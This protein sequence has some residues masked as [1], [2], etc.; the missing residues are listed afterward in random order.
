MKVVQERLRFG[1]PRARRCLKMGRFRSRAKKSCPRE[2]EDKDG[3]PPQVQPG[4]VISRRT[5]RWAPES[6][7]LQQGGGRKVWGQVGN[8]TQG[9]TDK[10]PKP[11]MWLLGKVT[12]GLLG[13]GLLNVEEEQVVASWPP[14]FSK[15]VHLLPDP[16]PDITHHL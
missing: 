5:V 12:N 7:F 13:T 9:W 1:K 2:Q 15:E 11:W 4:A 14:V 6:T 8:R 10:T 16:Q 3:R